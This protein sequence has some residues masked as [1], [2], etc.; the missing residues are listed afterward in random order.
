MSRSKRLNIL[1]TF[2]S[3]LLILWLNAVASGQNPARKVLTAMDT[4]NRDLVT[5]RGRVTRVD[6]NTQLRVFDTR[7]G[8]LLYAHD[9][10]GNANKISVRVDFERPEESLAIQNGRYYIY[11]KGTNQAY[12]G[13]V[14]SKRGAPNSIPLTFIGMTRP[15]LESKYTYTYLGRARLQNGEDTTHL[16]LMPKIKAQYSHVEI[17]VNDNGMPSQTKVVQTNGDSTTILISNYAINEKIDG[18]DFSIIFPK[19]ARVHVEK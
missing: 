19:T 15:E 3:F 17:W 12:E 7:L 14:S 5:V 4:F 1:S 8:K 13:P 9:K 6:E 16:K 18:R 2:V 10:K 11:V